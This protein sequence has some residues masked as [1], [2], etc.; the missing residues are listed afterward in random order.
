MAKLVS[1]QKNCVIF[2]DFLLPRGHDVAVVSTEFVLS[3]A[4]VGR[5]YLEFSQCVLILFFHLCERPQYL[6]K[7]IDLASALTWE[8]RFLLCLLLMA[9]S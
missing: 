1:V 7:Q 5:F 8:Q 9:F 4:I 6:K 3:I 2:A